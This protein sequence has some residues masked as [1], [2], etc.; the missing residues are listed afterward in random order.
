MKTHDEASDD[1]GSGPMTHSDYKAPDLNSEGV[2]YQLSGMYEKWFIDYASYVILDRAVPHI[3][4]GL[5]PVQRRIL[6]TMKRLDDGRFNKVA[7]IVGSTMQFHPHGDASI[8]DALVGLGQKEL[9]VE[10]QGNWGNIFTGDG[11][12]AARYIEARLSKFA[13]DIAFNNK[14]TEWKMSYDGRNEE[15]ITLPVKFPLLLAQGAN[16]IAV[17][18]SSMILPHNFNEIIDAA[19]KYLRGEDFY[20]YPDFPTGGMVDVSKYN[21]GA[22]GGRVLIRSHISKIDNKTLVIT[23]IPFGETTKTVIESIVKANEKGKINIKKVDDDT[24]EKVEIVIQLE[25]KTSSDKTIDALYAFTNCQKSISPVCCVIQDKKPLFTNVKYLLKASVDHTKDL[26]RQELEIKRAELTE[27][28]FYC[29]LEKI[30]IEER[31]YK[32]KDFE[33]ARDIDAAVAHI[34]HR[35]EPFKPMLVRDVTRDDILR[36]LEIKMARIL[37][38]NTFKSEE[39][40]VA[41]KGQIDEVNNHL[42]HLVQFTIDWYE[43][44]KAKYGKKHP[45]LTE[46]R[47]FDSINATKVAEAN[48]KL[49]VNREEGFIGTGLKKD[50]FVC[51]CSDLDDVIVFFKDGKYKVV[52]VADKLYVGK[53][54][55]YLN[56]F[57]KKDNRTVY[58]AVYHDGRGGAYYI[59]RFAVPSITRDKEYDLTQGKAGSTV[60]YFTA[61][62][63]AE[64]E[65]I[66]VFLRPKPHM[67]NN[68]IERDFGE[69]AVKG[70]QSIGNLVT[71]NP[72]HSIVLKRKGGS[73]MGGRKVWFD[74]DV[75]RL[76]YEE[77]GELLGEFQS[78]DLVLV[79]LNNGD[80]YTTDFGESN[81]F[82]ENILKVEKWDGNKTWTAV[83]Y[84]ANEGYTYIKRF[85]MEPSAKPV[86]FLGDNPKSRLMLLTCTAYPR[87]EVHYGGRDAEKEP[88]EIDAEQFISVKGVKAKGKRLCNNEVE[89]VVELEPLRLPQDGQEEG[90]DDENLENEEESSGMEGKELTLF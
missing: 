43:T 29:S 53:N 47:N 67:K 83:L 66:K 55:L 78:D 31:I 72:V 19:V 52:K 69:I 12:A 48:E 24:S 28:L 44:I 50:E 9:M 33:Q 75:L 79:V 42:A 46:I 15:P 38:F 45:R 51:N 2:K 80:Y 34:D 27:Q 41:L 73:T 58:N 10:T 17:S 8:K 7:N 84:D 59:K 82:E 68:I 56:V 16:G 4:D 30:F 81:H 60:V 70:R 25:A 22:R 14:T 85:Q 40:I 23:D 20:L 77:R 26:L 86:N 76:N 37:K 18:L 5:K 6:H 65:V 61:N 62:P 32:D 35:L 1:F 71:R 11:A 63:N 74:S 54:I 90:N 89:R 36:L 88:F 64:A 21:N 13:L 87:I 39:Q 49:Y 57:K 3:E